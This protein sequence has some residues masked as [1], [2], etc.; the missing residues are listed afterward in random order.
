MLFIIIGA[1][2][3]LSLIVLLIVCSFKLVRQSTAIVIE[4]LG[5]FHRVLGPGIHFIIP[6]IDKAVVQV[7][8]DWDEYVGRNNANRAVINLKERVA[9][10]PKQSVITKDNAVVAIDTVVFF[11]VTDPKL[12]IYGAENPYEAF[13]A[14]TETTV[15]NIVGELE[16]DQALTSREFIN[17]KLCYTLDEAADAWGIKIMRVEVQ[18]IEPPE[19]V[20]IAM[21]K[22][23]KA[24]R[25]R[26]EAILRAEGEKRSAILVAE[27]ESEARILNAK[28]KAEETILVA[29]AKANAIKLINEANPSAEY[30]T[31][32]GYKAVKDLADGQATK[33][34][35]PS[36]IQ[37]IAGLFASLKAVVAEDKLTKEEEE[38]KF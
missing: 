7:L 1:V 32:E 12:F 15:R 18:E 11:Q 19:D 29:N 10:F 34:V 35:V 5:K 27:G 31:L 30:L 17:K 4:R 36:D 13:R 26:R 3:L 38:F 25:E 16:L 33:I 22:Q 37:N 28:A 2:I 8:G 24:E 23:M 14:L 9:N 20:Q 21:H 6:I